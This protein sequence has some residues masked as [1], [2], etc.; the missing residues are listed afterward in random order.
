[1]PAVTVSQAAY[2]R[3]TL[4][5]GKNRLR[6][7]AIATAGRPQ[8]AQYADQAYAPGLPA[9]VGP[10]QTAPTRAPGLAGGG[11]QFP[12]CGQKKHPKADIP[13]Q[14]IVHT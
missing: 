9:I 5:A 8:A 1:M 13:K 14:T 6:A 10:M 12:I 7:D 11:G 3:D 4:P 2:D